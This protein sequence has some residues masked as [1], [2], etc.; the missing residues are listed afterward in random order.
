[1]CTPLVASSFDS[2]LRATFFRAHSRLQL[3]AVLL[4]Q[5][6]NVAELIR[7]RYSSTTAV[8]RVSR[9]QKLLR[10]RGRGPVL[11]DDRRRGCTVSA[12]NRY[13][14]RLSNILGSMLFQ[15]DR[16]RIVCAQI[17]DGQDES[18]TSV[19]ANRQRS[20]DINGDLTK[21]FGNQGQAVLRYWWTGSILAKRP[22]LWTIRR[23]ST[24]TP[25]VRM[26]I[27]H[28][29]ARRQAERCRVHPW[30]P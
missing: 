10:R 21:R 25:Q 9:R 11:S 26:V 27:R 19:L 15:R 13:R 20:N 16:L 12:G 8:R 5:S 29:P 2:L 6:V 4:V 22:A 3:K 30:H 17:K 28:R 24:L 7:A 18:V 23:R 14:Q 1:M